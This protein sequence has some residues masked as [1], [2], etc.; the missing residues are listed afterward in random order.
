MPQHS[1]TTRW[2]CPACACPERSRPLTFPLGVPD[3]GRAPR[4]AITP[5]GYSTLAWVL[6]PGYSRPDTLSRIRGRELGATR[7]RPF[8]PLQANASKTLAARSG[9]AHVG[10]VKAVS[11]DPCHACVAPDHSVSTLGLPEVALEAALGLHFGRQT[12]VT[13]GETPTICRLSS[14]TQRPPRHS[15]RTPSLDPQERRAAHVFGR[16]LRRRLRPRL[17]PRA[18]RDRNRSVDPAVG[19]HPTRRPMNPAGF[20]HSG[21]ASRLLPESNTRNRS[22]RHHVAGTTPSTTPSR[23]SSRTVPPGPATVRD[24]P[25]T[26]HR[27]HCPARSSRLRPLRL[28]PRSGTASPV[29]LPLPAA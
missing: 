21:D 12:W 13:L 20:Q 25:P 24:A 26:L 16:R 8:G 28:N 18:S 4:L 5:P 19:R 17:P 9:K 3:V 22:S 11:H 1:P 6:S 27:E 2:R 10:L 7:Y 29:D 23:T 14:P 15:S